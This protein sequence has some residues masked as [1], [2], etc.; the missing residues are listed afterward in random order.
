MI[1]VGILTVLASCY[2]T[3][4]TTNSTSREGVDLV[5]FHRSAF[6]SSFS[7]RVFEN[8]HII[9]SKVAIELD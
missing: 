6:C 9:K 3:G 1:E 8:Y 5:S 4:S 7:F 2:P